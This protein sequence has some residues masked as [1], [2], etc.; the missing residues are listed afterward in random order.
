MQPLSAGG[1]AQIWGEGERLLSYIGPVRQDRWRT[2]S[3]H[4]LHA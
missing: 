4:H 2:Y 1:R 3:Q